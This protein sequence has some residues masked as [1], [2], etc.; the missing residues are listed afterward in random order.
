MES[1]TEPICKCK[2]EGERRW[3][4]IVIY[5]NSKDVR[6][7]NISTRENLMKARFWLGLIFLWF[8]KIWTPENH[9][10]RREET[11]VWQLRTWGSPPVES[12][13]CWDREDSSELQV[14]KSS[15][16]VLRKMWSVNTWGVCGKLNPVLEGTLW[17]LARRHTFEFQRNKA[18]LHNALDEWML[19]FYN[20]QMKGTRCL[21]NF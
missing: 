6:K 3:V 18:I 21:W 9:Q 7:F 4:W 13:S 16:C 1:K 11:H 19:R 17:D 10:R 2:Y 15:A 14:A 5:S 12:R 20:L 8:V